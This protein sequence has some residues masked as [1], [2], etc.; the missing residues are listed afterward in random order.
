MKF[1]TLPHASLLYLYFPLQWF[2]L[3][4]LFLTHWN[5]KYIVVLELGDANLLWCKPL[6]QLFSWSLSKQNQVAGVESIWKWACAR[7]EMLDHGQYLFLVWNSA[8]AL[9]LVT[10]SLELY[11]DETLREKR[12]YKLESFK[13][14]HLFTI[15]LH[16]C[17]CRL[18]CESVPHYI[19]PLACPVWIN[20]HAVYTS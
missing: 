11:D 8:H 3:L 2:G 9:V 16:Q 6:M 5:C 12:P 13:S 10:S 4:Y 1:F 17:K 19:P 14:W 15:S 20:T 18:N 7:A